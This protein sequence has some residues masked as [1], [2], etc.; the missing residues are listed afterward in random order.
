MV[1]AVKSDK[2]RVREVNEDSYKIITDIP[3]FPYVF[4]IADGMGG[5]NSGEVASSTAV[6][7]ATD[8]I[9]NLSLGFTGEF[10]PL[11]IIKEIMEQANN[12]VFNKSKEKI[13]NAGMGTTLII[14]IFYEGK[15]FVGHIG[16]SRAYL[17]RDGNM[18]QITTDHSYV[19]ELVRNGSLTREEAENHPQKNIITRA[20]GC[21][22][23]M[24]IDTYLCDL[25][26]N[27]YVLLCTD[28]LTNMLTEKEIMEII[29]NA[30]NLQL[31]CQNL[32][33]SANEN[34]G[35]DN[36]TVI[37]VKNVKKE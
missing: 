16:D 2:G 33:D 17:I 12:I 6:K 24:Q 13:S 29:L 32:V 10:D 36:I 4:I 28:G 23:E 37:A 15:V 11:S 19:E 22:Q 27:D 1:Y 35:Y 21:S 30:P 14:A 9:H 20:L 25:L 7:A 5:H 8:Y 18:V 26:E 3:G 31:A 34:G